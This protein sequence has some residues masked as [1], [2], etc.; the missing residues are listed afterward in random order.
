MGSLQS[1][2]RPA[3][4]CGVKDSIWT[5]PVCLLLPKLFGLMIH[6]SN[7]S[8]GEFISIPSLPVCFWREREKELDFLELSILGF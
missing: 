4:G 3:R 8:F 1:M 6:K 2:L 5:Y 7:M